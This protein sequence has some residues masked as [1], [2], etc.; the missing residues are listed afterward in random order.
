MVY[1]H[2]FD[3]AIWWDGFPLIVVQFI[4]AEGSRQSEAYLE[5][6]VHHGLDIQLAIHIV[7]PWGSNFVALP[8]LRLKR[9]GPQETVVRPQDA[10]RSV[11]E[12]VGPKDC[13]SRDCYDTVPKLGCSPCAL[14]CRFKMTSKLFLSGGDLGIRRIRDVSLLR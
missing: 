1:L 8:N 2:R 12:I 9:F 11:V 3:P 7:Q 5:Q 13:S 4:C 6:K 14:M 10:I